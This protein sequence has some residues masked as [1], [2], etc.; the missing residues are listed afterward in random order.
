MD[1]QKNAELWNRVHKC[2]S[3]KQ[4]LVTLDVSIPLNL[5]HYFKFQSASLDSRLQLS[6]V[7]CN[8]PSKVTE[9]STG[10]EWAECT[11]STCSYQFCRHCKCQRH[12]GKHC[13]QYDL[14]RPSPSKRKKNMCAVG[15]KNS[16]RN[17]RRLLWFYVSF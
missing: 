6:C 16:K 11:S 17:L 13:F 12:P 14:N 1:F 15:T 10:E 3:S 7:R 9:E 8:Q 2:G 5:H 4:I